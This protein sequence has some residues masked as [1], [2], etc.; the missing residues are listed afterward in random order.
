LLTQPINAS[1]KNKDFKEKRT[2]IFGKTSSQSFPLTNDLVH[3]ESWTEDK[4][5]VRHEKLVMLS[6]EMLGLA[7][8][9]HGTSR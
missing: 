5:R 3:Y 9:W 8:R 4:L 7:P 6:F 1:A 2:V